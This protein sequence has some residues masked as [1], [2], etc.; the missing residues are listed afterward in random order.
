MRSIMSTQSRSQSRGQSRSQSRTQFRTASKSSSRRTSGSSKPVI[1]EHKVGYFQTDLDV[2]TIYVGNLRYTRD[3][4]SIKEM[5]KE[6]G[7]VKYVK[8][9]VDPKTDK[10]KGIA[11]VQ[12]P[13][14]KAATTA[15]TTMNGKQ[16]DG[17]TLKVSIATERNPAAR[18]E[19]AQKTEAARLARRPRK[20][21]A[22]A[23]ELEAQQAEEAAL[24][25]PRRRDKKQ[26]LEK[27]FDYLKQK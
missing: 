14:K 4:H 7:T 24:K 26:S 6:F 8:M 22:K 11:F 5:F 12:M 1:N 18:A 16:V 21:A 20:E 15:I 13:N 2:T 23:A 27:L 3:E 17:R 9:V 19:A 10:S 25:R